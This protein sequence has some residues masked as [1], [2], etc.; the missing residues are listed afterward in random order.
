MDDKSLI[1]KCTQHQ[2]KNDKT[3]RETGAIHEV[4][5]SELTIG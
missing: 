4:G 5:F 1:D 3:E 2:Q